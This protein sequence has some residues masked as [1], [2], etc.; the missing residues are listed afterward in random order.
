MIRDNHAEKKVTLKM[1]KRE[2]ITLLKQLGYNVNKSIFDNASNEIQVDNIA[3]SI[4]MAQHTKER[5][6]KTMNKETR[7]AIINKEIQVYNSYINLIPTIAEIIEKFNNKCINKKFTEALDE[8]VNNGKTGQER[9]F[10][11]FT[12]FG[13]SGQFEITVHAYDDSVKEIVP[14][15]EYPSYH[16]VENN[17][18][19]FVIPKANF[20][21]T[22]SGNYRIKAELM[23]ETLGEHEINILFSIKALQKGIEQ[24]DEMV[25]EMKR[26]K[27][28]LEAFNNKY[29]FHMRDLMGVNYTFRD[30]SSMQYRNYNI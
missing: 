26:I 13:Y 14:T 4:F 8:A 12:R 19:T 22:D 29:D 1:Y 23:I 25:Q 28:E 16:R 24:A 11:I 6:G 3:H 5:K 10:Y 2:K 9:K 30:N 27:A 18:Y 17:E 7:I 20:E 15:K 21:I